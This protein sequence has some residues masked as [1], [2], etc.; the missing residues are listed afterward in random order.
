MKKLQ[1]INSGNRAQP[2]VEFEQSQGNRMPTV[3]TRPAPFAIARPPLV[4]ARGAPRAAKAGSG[5]GFR[6]LRVFLNVTAGAQA[7]R[8]LPE[9][10]SP[11]LFLSIRNSSSSAGSL[12]VGFGYPP[13]GVDTCDYELAAGAVLILDSVTGIP[14]DDV[15][16][17]STGGASGVIS[18]GVGSVS[19]G[20]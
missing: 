11:R 20:K 3:T 1:F 17:F 8:V 13:I 12:L 16:V 14:Q 15:W 4:S 9:S 18:Y 10:N 2:N 5:S 6:M 7:A 19:R